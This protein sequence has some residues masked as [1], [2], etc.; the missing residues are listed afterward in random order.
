MGTALSVEQVQRELHT[1]RDEVRTLSRTLKKGR[2]STLSTDHPYIVRV[3]G[4]RGGEPIIRG[5]GICVRTIIERFR[6]LNETP[7][8]IA[9]AYPPLTLSQVYAALS[10]YYDHPQEIEAYITENEAA[11]W[12]KLPTLQN[13]Y[14]NL[15]EFAE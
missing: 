6:L 5:T 1:L 3:D 2:K 14:R 15:A 4:V 10:Y 8:Q 12:K 11:L 7:E 13:T 9:S